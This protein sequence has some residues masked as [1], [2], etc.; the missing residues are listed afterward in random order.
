MKK[1]IEFVVRRVQEKNKDGKFEPLDEKFSIIFNKNF[2]EISED[3]IEIVSFANKPIPQVR[4]SIEILRSFLNTEGASDNYLQKTYH[5]LLRN[6][7]TSYDE[8]RLLPEDTLSENMDSDPYYSLGSRIGITPSELYKTL[9]ISPDNLSE[10]KLQE[11]F[12]L[13]NTK[14]YPTNIYDDLKIVK[15]SLLFK[16]KKSNLYE[17]WK[18][19]DKIKVID[20]ENKEVGYPID[21]NK[22]NELTITDSQNKTIRFPF[23]VINPEYLDESDFFE[24]GEIPIPDDNAGIE[25][26][27]E[28]K[29]T[30][31]KLNAIHEL[32]HIRKKF[33]E[34][35]YINIESFRKSITSSPL[36]GFDKTLTKVLENTIYKDSDAKI[37][38]KNISSD[39]FLQEVLFLVNNGKKPEHKVDI[40]AVLSFIPLS[41]SE[42]VLLG[43]IRNLANNGKIERN[44]WKDFYKILVRMKKCYSL[45]EWVLIEANAGI[46]L[47]P[48]FFKKNEFQLEEKFYKKSRKKRKSWQGKLN[49]RIKQ[50]KE[51]FEV[52]QAA[53]IA[54]EI[55]TL[56]ILRD[57]LIG[58]FSEKIVNSENIDVAD[59]LSQRFFIDFK[60][61]G[62]QIISRI[63]QA[64]ESLQDFIL[65]LRAGHFS[66]KELKVTLNSDNSETRIESLPNWEIYYDKKYSENHFD[67]EWKWYGSFNTWRGA[68]LAIDYPENYLLPTLWYRTQDQLPDKH[69]K[70]T[71]AFKELVKKI[72]QSGRLTPDSVERLAEAYMATLKRP[73]IKN[74][75][76]GIENPIEEGIEKPV[77]SELPGDGVSEKNIPDLE[78]IKLTGNLSKSGLS[79]LR[80]LSYNL[81]KGSFSE[82]EELKF[83]DKEYFNKKRVINY[84]QPVGKVDSAHEKKISNA[85]F[86]CL[87][88]ILFF[89]PM[90]FAQALQ[91]NGEF[92]SAL[93]WY[94][95]IYSFEKISLTKEQLLLIEKTNKYNEKNKSEP[96]FKNNPIPF[97][98]HKIYYG[99]KEE[100]LIETNLSIDNDNLFLGEIDDLITG[101]DIFAIANDRANAYTSSTIL[102]IARCYLAYADAEFTRESNESIVLARR[103]YMNALKILESLPEPN[104]DSNKKIAPNPIKKTLFQ[105]GSANLQKLHN[106]LN[107]AGMERVRRKPADLELS[108]GEFGLTLPTQNYIRSTAYRYSVLIE[109]SK[110]LVTLAQQIEANF[111]SVLEKKDNEN[112]NLQLMNQSVDLTKEAVELQILRVKD[113]DYNANIVSLQK[114]R[115]EVQIGTYTTWIE[116]GPND[117]E[118]KMLNNY[119]KLRDEKNGLAELE[120]LH[121]MV[122]SWTSMFKVTS[123]GEAIGGFINFAANGLIGGSK[124][125]KQFQ[126]NSL[127][128]QAQYNSFQ[129]NYSRKKDEWELQRSLS[130]KDMEIIN[131][132]INQAD[133]NKEI[134]EQEKEI[135]D[136]TANQAKANVEFLRNKFTSVE[137][138]EWM[139][140]V[141]SGIYSYF[142]Q[143]ATATAQ[144]A[145]NQL[146]FER[147]E[148]LPAFISNDY[149]QPPTASVAIGSDEQQADRRGLTGSARLLQDI[150]KLDQHAFDT[151]K[152]KHQL[153]QNFSLSQL[154]PYEFQQFRATGILPFV[155]SMSMFDQGFPGHYL[156]LIKRIRISIIAL[157]PPLQGIRATLSSTGISRVVTGGDI[158]R[159]TEIQRLSDMIVFTSPSNATGLFEMQPESEMLLPFE[160]MGVDSSWEL[161]LPKASNHFNF[162]SIAD[163]IFTMEYTS[164]HSYDYQR[165]VIEKLDRNFSAER[166]YSIK[167]DFPDLWYNLHHP[168]TLEDEGDNIRAS[169]TIQ[170]THFPPNLIGQIK[171]DKII[172]Y[173]VRSEG[174]T[175]EI[176]VADLLLNDESIV[177]NEEAP[178]RVK[179]VNGAISSRLGGASNGIDVIGKDPVGKWSLVFPKD[180]KLTQSLNDKKIT[181]VLFVLGY[182]GERPAWV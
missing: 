67:A 46:F 78:K 82:G 116:N 66:V 32:F 106:N 79:E 85:A 25:A 129:A 20:S 180:Q 4:I 77:I 132:Q 162:D 133:N 134:L 125:S 119:E 37:I 177:L 31:K 130:N 166:P 140:D 165:Q 19:Q 105:H 113:A 45:K 51:L 92:L 11:V 23:P 182:S 59:W 44:E 163:V 54:T 151:N 65:S 115:T 157:V 96:E 108:I 70:Y 172:I 126:I 53:I 123:P 102:S 86:Y 88:E 94:Q 98:E 43:K 81:L 160:T 150:Y 42:L 84:P 12:G 131:V 56:P 47:N 161:C 104:S 118:V 14:I 141:L 62:N 6:I 128:E 124:L 136:I 55:A 63:D 29:Q 5:S 111:L 137:L 156:R 139:S 13:V 101:L 10:E 50:Q 153:V 69:K 83:I 8:I 143:Q 41:L 99:L 16:E 87:R 173:F 145:A 135:A 114:E 174:T 147:Q 60:A 97:D 26:K 49:L 164:L 40:D 159:E 120:H 146:S 122:S 7:G 34:D 58:K 27:D 30:L 72:R 154:F 35:E 110:Q 71:I 95:R 15:K 21:L 93:D 179:S 64:L 89:I 176:E 171:V 149:W 100:E 127:E 142:L 17:K 167:Q 91:K 144:L 80:F 169:F 155:T 75:T 28:Y 57:W 68:M 178:L 61:S 76:E 170:R 22:L 3:K 52:Y 181:D 48:D 33:L 168:E 90:L 117:H 107:I 109:R 175:T 9:Y 36:D 121:S 103:M 24:Q 2:N 38:L 158:F 152:R 138:Y 1:L 148:Y 112:Y 73:F 74:P 39:D 18:E